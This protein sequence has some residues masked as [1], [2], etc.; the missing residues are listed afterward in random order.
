MRGLRTSLVWREQKEL[1][2]HFAKARNGSTGCRAFRHDGMGTGEGTGV[3]AADHSPLCGN[4]PEIFT[5]L[6]RSVTAVVSLKSGSSQSILSIL[7]RLS[8]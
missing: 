6:A 4:T 2:V 5:Y 8:T 3:N 1:I 7:K